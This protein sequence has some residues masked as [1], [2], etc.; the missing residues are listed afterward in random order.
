MK[1]DGGRAL[2]RRGDGEGRSVG[3]IKCRESRERE[4]RSLTGEKQS[5]GFAIE[6]GWGEVP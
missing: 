4:L 5:L 6:L 2:G 3:E 1:V